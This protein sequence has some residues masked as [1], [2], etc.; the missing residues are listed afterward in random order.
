MEVKESDGGAALLSRESQELDA[1]RCIEKQHYCQ[2]HKKACYVQIDGSHYQ[3]TTSDLAKWAY[4]LV[5][6]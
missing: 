1:L 3:Y 5:R 4:L 2:A 6:V